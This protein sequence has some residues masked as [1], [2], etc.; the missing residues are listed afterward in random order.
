MCF[1][2]DASGGIWKLD[3]SF[4]FTSLQPERFM[5]YHSGPIFSCGASPVSQLVATVGDDC[6]IAFSSIIIEKLPVLCKFQWLLII[7]NIFV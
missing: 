2:Q 5:Y 7:T 3:L 1:I 4:Q 6:R